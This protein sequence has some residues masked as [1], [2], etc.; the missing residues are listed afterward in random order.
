M[1][2]IIFDLEWN[3]SP[4]GKD[5]ENPKIPFEILE[6]GA[7][8]V[9]NKGQILDT[10]RRIIKPQIYNEL[11][12]IIRDITGFTMKQLRK[13]DSFK[14]VAS[15]FLDWCGDE[16]MFCTWG[17]LDVFELLRNMDYYHMDLPNK[18]VYYIN[19]QKIYSLMY[20]N[21]AT[22]SRSLEYAVEYLHIPIS[23]GF[24]RAMEDAMYTALVFAK[25]DISV[26]EANFSID[27]YVH[28]ATKDDEFTQVF[29]DCSKYLSIEFEN[30][31]DALKD[32]DVSSTIC[33]KC[34]RRTRKKIR[35]FSDNAKT[36]YCLAHCPEHGYI[37]GQIRMKKGHGDNCFVIKK[38]MITDDI[39]ADNIRQKQQDI[40]ERRKR[41]RNANRANQQ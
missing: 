31:N 21:S 33:Y 29:H 34:G 36:Y 12:Y 15:D 30:K 20:E 32:K 25:L 19:L 10:F 23:T 37:S 2:Y 35:W 11:H 40:K 8:K 6:I 39:G 13:G 16:Y 1:N 28:P 9:N 24:H 3:Q 7:V 27:C 17:S 14:R 4:R 38:L 5:G 22:V 18:S 41:K 26:I